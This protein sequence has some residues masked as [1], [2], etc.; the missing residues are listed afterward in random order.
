MLGAVVYGSGDLSI[1]SS[2]PNS[3]RLRLGVV[4]GGSSKHPKQILREIRWLYLSELVPNIKH[5]N[6]KMGPL[7]PQN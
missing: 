5:T 4:C 1:H 3:K 6:L 7:G 2:P